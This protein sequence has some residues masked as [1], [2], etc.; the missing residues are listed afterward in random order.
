MHL[1]RKH[2][3]PAILCVLVLSFGILRH[4]AVHV[5]VGLLMVTLS[6]FVLAWLGAPSKGRQGSR[7]R[8]VGYAVQGVA[9]L[10]MGWVMAESP[11]S[12]LWFGAFL[13]LF[14]VGI[15]ISQRAVAKGRRQGT[16]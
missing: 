7:A 16:A 5:I 1:S 2:L 4:A 3:L 6:V 12:E 9:G 15:Q 13:L 8:R 11:R 14:I 10:G